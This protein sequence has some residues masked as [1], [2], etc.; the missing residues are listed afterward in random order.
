MSARI[1]PLLRSTSSSIFGMNASISLGRAA[2]ASRPPPA[3]RISTYRDTVFASHPASCAA[4]QAVPVRSNASRISTISLPDLVMD[5]SGPMGKANHLKPI[6]TGG[7]T[8]IRT[9]W[10]PAGN[11]PL[12]WTV[13]GPQDRRN[14]GREPGA[15]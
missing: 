5:P 14:D 2:R 10:T 3:S 6:H 11:W 8:S 1:L 4:D 12:T 15:N 7:I 9:R 13:D